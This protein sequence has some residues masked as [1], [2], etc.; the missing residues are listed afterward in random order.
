MKK[1]KIRIINDQERFEDIQ[2]EDPYA[3]NRV[4]KFTTQVTAFEPAHCLYQFYRTCYGY[5]EHDAKETA[6]NTPIKILKQTPDKIHCA[7]KDYGSGLKHDV[8]FLNLTKMFGNISKD[9]TEA[10]LNL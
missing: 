2:R 7:F 6:G 3:D 9:D 10:I 8:T 1:V 5:D 4:E